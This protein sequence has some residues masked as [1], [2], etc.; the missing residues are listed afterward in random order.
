V[1]FKGAPGELIVTDAD[2]VRKHLSVKMSEHQV[3]LNEVLALLDLMGSRPASVKLIGV[4]PK[5]MI[6]AGGLS[7]EA[8]RRIPEVI[9]ILKGEIEEASRVV[10]ERAVLVG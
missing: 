1:N 3:T 4:Q 7:D 5:H 8:R 6:F 2:Q 9:E 10:D